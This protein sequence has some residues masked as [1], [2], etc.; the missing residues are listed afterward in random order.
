M[1]GLNQAP[2]PAEVVIH[3]VAEDGAILFQLHPHVMEVDSNLL[4]LLCFEHSIGDTPVEIEEF[5]NVRVGNAPD[6][7]QTLPPSATE[8]HPAG[9]KANNIRKRVGFH[10]SKDNQL[11]RQD[12]SHSEH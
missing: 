8:D 3:S 2:K 5:E 10:D 12:M 1:T 6:F 11:L 7:Y 4:P 9:P